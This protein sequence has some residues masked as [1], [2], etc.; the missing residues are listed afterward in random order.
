M[1]ENTKLSDFQ[2]E[3]DALATLRDELKLKARL[4]RAELQAQL[5]ELEHR[6]R[7]AEEQLRRTKDHVK[8]DH[9]VIDRKIS[10]LLSD[11]KLGYQNV[12]QAFEAN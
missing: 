8:Q 11:L 7:L 9:Q 4:A 5:D 3:L 12:K 1:N 10:N 6:W 2:R